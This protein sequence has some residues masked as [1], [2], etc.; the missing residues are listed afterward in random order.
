MVLTLPGFLGFAE[1]PALE[2]GKL[3]KS[4][5]VNPYI[6]S[7]DAYGHWLRELRDAAG[8]TSQLVEFPYDWRKDN[9]LSAADLLGLVNSLRASGVHKITIVAHSMGGLL[10]AYFLRY[11]GQDPRRRQ[12]KLGRV[13][14]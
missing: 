12:W 13:P 3:I 5:P 9:V 1:V 7:H 10:T 6:Y 2:R 11:G 14:G 8:A 4:V